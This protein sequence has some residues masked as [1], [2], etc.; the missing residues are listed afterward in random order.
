[1]QKRYTITG[2]FEFSF[3]SQTDSHLTPV[4]MSMIMLR[5]MRISCAHRNVAFPT[6]DVDFANG[7]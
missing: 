5:C 3:Y 1:M 7:T 2:D 6:L 4:E